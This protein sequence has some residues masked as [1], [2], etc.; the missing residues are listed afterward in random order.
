MINTSNNSPWKGYYPNVTPFGNSPRYNPN[1]ISSLYSKYTSLSED[2][3]TT[4]SI[5][6]IDR[7]YA[8]IEAE[9]D[10]TLLTFNDFGVGALHK[11]K[12]KDHSKGG[13]PLNVPDGSFIY[14]KDKSL[15]FTPEEI[16]T[17]GLGK[18]QKGGSINNTPS[19]VLQKNIDFK[20]N[21]KMI[22]LLENSKN[23][24]EKNT[25]LRMLQKY[26]QKAGT[27][28]ALQE[29]RKTSEIPEFAT[30]LPQDETNKQIA[31][32]YSKGGFVFQKGGSYRRYSPEVQGLIS[33]GRL[34]G[35]SDKEW[36]G[37]QHLN[38]GVYG[39]A[40][41]NEF[42]NRHS[43]FFKN[44]P[45][46]SI[47][48]FQKAYNKAYQNEFGKDYFTGDDQ[49]GVDGKLGDYTYGAPLINRN[50]T[51]T[52][53]PFISNQSDVTTPS[54]TEPVNYVDKAVPSWY[55]P[56]SAPQENLPNTLT[57]TGQSNNSINPVSNSVT[58]AGEEELRSQFD[59][60]SWIKPYDMTS[61]YLSMIGNSLQ[62]PRSFYPSL[63]LQ[64]APVL[65]AQQFDAQPG[66]N[67]ALA[68]AYASR[69]ANQ[70]YAPMNLQ[71]NQLI[72]SGASKMAMDYASQID[73]ANQSNATQIHNQN[74]LAQNQAQNYNNQARGSYKDKLNELYQNV[75]DTR[76]AIGAT[77][78]QLFG[79]ALNENKTYDQQVDLIK[80]M[81]QWN[82]QNKM[83]K[84]STSD[85]LNAYQQIISQHHLSE[86]EQAQLLQKM[87][88]Q[89]NQQQDNTLLYQM[90]NQLPR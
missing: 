77:N 56:M 85:I 10:E 68:S 34:S 71:N 39:T 45:Q 88:N 25:A 47:L 21:N 60:L 70:M 65:R 67:A 90:M 57:W 17:F 5:K 83:N 35:I 48:D 62:S 16:K 72:D 82:V 42:K 50:S 59:D 23:L 24:A 73:R 27:I 40:Q 63:A 12:G 2:G 43:W 11:I 54:S 37:N 14:S 76:N 4:D 44:N 89:N 49:Y 19:K 84:Q 28:A 41:E 36:T 61:K 30:L 18:Y 6:P 75:S 79:D 29:I 64:T 81:Q 58:N 66:I 26:Q 31:K 7:E 9:K 33:S 15:S 8:N 46:G 55:P 1:T 86:R 51:F 20:H 78:L 53:D 69:K 74:V 3:D 22:D 38:N 13:T 80:R 87:L 52:Y 32:Q